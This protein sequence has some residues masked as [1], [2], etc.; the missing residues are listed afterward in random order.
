M[1]S[2]LIPIAGSVI[3]GLMSKSSK[4]KTQ[5]QTQTNDP[6]GPAQ[7]WMQ[8]NIAY[9]QEL[10]K[11]YQ[12]NP[13][14]EIQQAG[15]KGLLGNLD[16]FS[17]N[18]APGLLNWVSQ[19]MQGGYQRQN[20]AAPGQV[21]YGQRVA[22]PAQQPE[23]RLFSTP[24]SNYAGLLNFQQPKPQAP[25]QTQTMPTDAAAFDKAMQEYQRRERERQMY[26]PSENWPTGLGA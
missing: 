18:T 1:P 6:W 14:N 9:G 17:N 11:H 10:Q 20:A 24:Q 26:T 8:N 16:N 22:Q 3:G 15:Y 4:G 7:P 23:Q 13:F 12:D 25:A 21:G 2:S 19:N 5:T